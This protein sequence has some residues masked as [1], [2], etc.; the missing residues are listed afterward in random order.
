MLGTIQQKRCKVIATKRLKDII[1]EW[2]EILIW[3][4]IE[5]KN[6]YIQPLC[7]LARG[8]RKTVRDSFQLLHKHT[9]PIKTIQRSLQLFGIVCAIPTY[10]V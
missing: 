9:T 7:S 10:Q 3:P 4:K 5:N 2:S 6:C 8:K 1:T